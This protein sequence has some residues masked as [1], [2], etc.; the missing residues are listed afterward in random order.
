MSTDQAPLLTPDEILDR[1]GLSSRS[2]EGG[3]WPLE[4]VGRAVRRLREL[5]AGADP[6]TRQL[7]RDGAIRRLKIVT[8]SPAKVVD[9][10]L[11][12][13]APAEPVLETAADTFGGGIIDVVR[14]G[15]KLRWLVAQ[16]GRV[17]FEDE[18]EG[19]EPWARVGLPWKTIP[20]AEDVKA[21][22]EAG[23][24]A[25]F[26][27]LVDL[28][29][30]RTVLPEPSSGWAALLAAWTLGTYLLDMFE[31]WPLLLFDGPP[32]RGKTRAAKAVLWPAFRG[33]YTPSPRAATIFRDRARHR[34]SLLLDIE[35]LPKM[36][37]RGDDIADL[38]LCSFERDGV[39]RRCTRPDAEPEKQIETF[40]AY[41]ATIVATNKPARD[42]S[43]LAS[44][45]IRISMPEAG[46][47]LVP[48]ALRPDEALILR[49]R[50]LAW[51]AQMEADGTGLPG[52]DTEFR[53]RLR[54]LAVPLLRILHHVSPD[55]VQAV[56]HV[57]GEADRSRREEFATSWEAMV[58]IA[59]WQTRDK[60]LRSGRAYCQ[61]VAAHLND[62]LPDS[63]HLSAQQ[64]G[65][66]RRAL[67]LRGG[68]GGSPPRAYILWP[69]DE[70]AKALHDRYHTPPS[71]EGPRTP[72]GS[73]GSEA[74]PTN[75]SSSD[76]SDP[77]GGRKGRKQV[78]SP[79]DLHETLNPS[80][81]SDASG[82]SGA[83]GKGGGGEGPDLWTG[84]PEGPGRDG[85]EGWRSV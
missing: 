77:G 21:A 38:L 68:K 75:T 32:E 19:R 29:Q 56:E 45:C 28:H 39:I 65:V 44:R 15:D 41:G 70:Q 4:A 58:A 60:A 74:T 13:M 47:K 78:G 26:R 40:A 18:H 23:G 20:T 80:D 34:I 25:P 51:R 63:D 48:N 11:S 84:G 82:P 33:A 57:L 73:E 12:D 3:D 43:P 30:A 71:P 85:V 2:L 42:T 9:A 5:L 55:H 67:G 81:A 10:A 46:R 37:E 66:A 36:L 31:Y 64:V 59:L 1:A 76:A 6:L 61:D 62:G 17:S 52:V 24:R 22:L 27:E 72:E 16:D 8:S 79:Q 7:C 50:C 83:P 69:G 14:E 53:G 49:A 54:D 35:D